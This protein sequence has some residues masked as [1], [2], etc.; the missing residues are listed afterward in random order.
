[1]ATLSYDGAPYPVRDDLAAAHAR[2]WDRIGSPG[3]WLDAETRVAIAA[4]VRQAPVCAL[5]RR[6]KESVS[7]Y[8]VEGPHDSLGALSEPQVEVVHRIVSDPARLT[9]A[10]YQRVLAA[11]MS[12]GEYVE[13][14]SLIAHTTALD[15]FAR[16]LG[17]AKQALPAPKS[18]T[19]SRYRPKEAR[20]N[21]HWVPTIAWGEHGPNEADYFVGNPSNI[22]MAMTLVPDET[23]SFFDLC[24]AQYLPGPAMFD[25]GREYRAISHAQ[26]ELLAGRVSAI[27]QCTY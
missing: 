24:I 25:F 15:T 18:G 1:M 10:W 13:I 27:N 16:A 5:C 12:E 9:R 2:V 11:G 3:T 22:R 7:P 17:F 26:I 19:P 6:R 21:Q 4:E 23:R 8:A 20:A 14:V